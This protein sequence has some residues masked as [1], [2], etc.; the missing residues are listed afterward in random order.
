MLMGL[1]LKRY[2]PGTGLGATRSRIENSGAILYVPNVP[3]NVRY[4]RRVL[5]DVLRDIRLWDG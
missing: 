3:N 2:L 1:Q 4:V 5:A